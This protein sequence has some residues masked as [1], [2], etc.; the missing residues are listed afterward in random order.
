[1][2]STKLTYDLPSSTPSPL[3][4]EEQIEY[5]FIGK[6]QSLKTRTVMTSVTAQP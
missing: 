1:M 6:L 3:V 4:R 5:D 2:S